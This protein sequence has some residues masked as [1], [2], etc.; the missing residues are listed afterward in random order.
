MSELT[1][2]VGIVG[3]HV[4]QS[5]SPVMHNAAY[6]EMGLDLRY[7]TFEIPQVAERQRAEFFA[8]F[9]D[10]QA[11]DGVIGL[12]VTMP[13]KVDA[14]RSERV[15]QG[16]SAVQAI[17]A[18]N[19]LSYSSQGIWHP[20]N[21]DWLGAVRSLEEQTEIRDKFAIVL[22]AGGTARAATFRFSRARNQQSNGCQ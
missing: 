18:A 4:E 7:G 14:L 19:T 8:A 17:G 11:E 2:N 6:Q 13:F 10:E 3:T 5:L 1:P 20:D 16:G 12:S 21:T 22:G 15:A 9:L